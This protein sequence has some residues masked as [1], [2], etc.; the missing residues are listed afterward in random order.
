MVKKHK[1]E[2]CKGTGVIDRKKHK[3]MV[4]CYDCNGTGKITEEE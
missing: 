2:K 3:M 4:T 1:C